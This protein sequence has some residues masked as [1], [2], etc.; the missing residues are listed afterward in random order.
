MLLD[1]K[2]HSVLVS[3][4]LEMIE[5]TKNSGAETKLALVMMKYIMNRFCN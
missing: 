4:K 3:Y 1:M 2:T 5:N